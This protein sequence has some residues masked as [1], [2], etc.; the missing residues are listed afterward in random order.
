MNMKKLYQFLS[1]KISRCPNDGMAIAIVTLIALMMTMST[2]ALYYLT[3]GFSKSTVTDSYKKQTNYL[4]ESAADKALMILNERIGGS[5]HQFIYNDNDTIDITSVVDEDFK[6]CLG[7]HGFNDGDTLT[8]GE[9]IYNVRYDESLDLPDLPDQD[10][11]YYSH[12]YLTQKYSQETDVLVFDGTNTMNLYGSFDNADSS[13]SRLFQTGFSIE[14]TVYLDSNIDGTLFSLYDLNNSNTEIEI[15]VT[16]DDF[17][18]V[19]INTV[20]GVTMTFPSPY[21]LNSNNPSHIAVTYS[22]TSG[23]LVIYIDNQVIAYPLG[24]EGYYIQLAESNSQYKFAFNNYSDLSGYITMLRIWDRELSLDEIT[25]LINDYVFNSVT[26][27]ELIAAFHFDEGSNNLFQ[28]KYDASPDVCNGSN[29]CYLEVSDLSSM[30]KKSVNNFTLMGKASDPNTETVDDLGDP[31]VDPSTGAPY[32]IFPSVVSTSSIY[33]ILSCGIFEQ[34]GGTDIISG[35][36]RFVKYEGFSSVNQ[37][38]V[39][40]RTY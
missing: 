3:S 18:T 22:N 17:V 10:L 9:Y 39:G 11:D 35:I 25:T 14:L 27:P 19:S 34:I 2:M 7:L 38:I 1:Y 29:D 32:V 26:N 37:S 5:G 23:N 33:R 31:Y 4:A 40:E 15:I 20:D 12:S 16:S 36:E 13:S 28:S 21:Q 24:D 8:T 6:K 30:Q